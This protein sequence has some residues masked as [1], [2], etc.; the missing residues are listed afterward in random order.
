MRTVGETSYAETSVQDVLERAGVSRKTFYEHFRDKQDCFLQAYDAV[1][2]RVMRAVNHAYQ[3]GAD[4]PDRVRRGLHVFLAFF[5]REPAIS[6]MAF[7]EV[8]A[9]GPEAI[10]R[11]RK[12]EERFIPY[13]EEGRAESDLGRDLPATLPHAIVAGVA[14]LI[15]R[16][17]A[18]GKP[19]RVPELEDDLLYFVLLPYLGP[20][21]TREIVS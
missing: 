20:E 11:Y 13:L 12:A 14:G 21:R 18:A 19:E 6:R 3:E 7:M 2:T 15:H 4:W 9:A 17:L 5:A 10:E 1:I 16:Q 8:L